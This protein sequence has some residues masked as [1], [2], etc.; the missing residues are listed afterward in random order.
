MNHQLLLNE[1]IANGLDVIGDR[2]TLLILREAFYGCT[3]F[4]VFCE[5]IS[6]SRA[7]LT[8]R[9]N[10]LIENEILYKAPYSESAKRFEYKFTQRGLSLT[11]SSLLAVQWEA[12]WRQNNDRQSAVVG[13]LRHNICGQKLAPK[14]VCRACKQDIKFDDVSW[15]D[16][17]EQLETQLQEIRASNAKHRKSRIKFNDEKVGTDAGLI[18]MVG[19]RWT[20]LILIACFFN[21]K[22]YD[23][24]IKQLNI[25]SSIL[26]E[27][28]K[29][30]A[31]ARILERTAYQQN[32][33][34]YEY[35]LTD[36]GKSLFP[37]I[38]SLRQWVVEQM[39][40]HDLGVNRL[41]HNACGQAL[42][43]DVVCG[44]CGQKPWPDDIEANTE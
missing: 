38:M 20:I 22:K 15:L 10:V 14:A 21:T 30:L 40:G 25:P 6:I 29:F 32:P 7:T 31:L 17:A 24:F 33:P 18:C 16:M 2:W 44:G 23:A 4:D 43:I 37:F 42:I 1:P 19:D 13:K 3:R 34:R 39:I 26:A 9:L 28:L 36:K 8:R 11:S 12:E 35:R 5:R 27:R 41:I